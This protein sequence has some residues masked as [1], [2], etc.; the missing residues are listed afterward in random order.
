MSASVG[1]FPINIKS[2]EN[3]DDDQAS[4][5][6]SINTAV[7]PLAS[8]SPSDSKRP[9][10]RLDISWVKTMFEGIDFNI[11]EPSTPSQLKPDGPALQMDEEVEEYNE[12]TS[13]VYFGYAD[14]P[15][16]GYP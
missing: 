13:D 9:D 8:K 6:V 10:P 16:F 15:N 4:G 2:P 11:E 5:G 14:E 7:D 1:T 12:D 3:S